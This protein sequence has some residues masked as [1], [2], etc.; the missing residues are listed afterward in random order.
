MITKNSNFPEF[1]RFKSLYFALA[2]NNQTYRNTLHTSCRKTVSNLLPKKRRKLITNKPIKDTTSLLSINKWLVDFSRLF[3]R[4][5]NR[6]LSNLMKNNSLWLFLKSQSRLKMP[7]NSLPFSVL[8]SRHP[9]F[10]ISS[11]QNLQVFYRFLFIL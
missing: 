2:L 6:R 11:Y 7:S 4:R 5:H 10:S 8:V 1:F 9:D 3:N